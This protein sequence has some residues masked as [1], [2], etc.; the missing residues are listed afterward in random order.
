MKRAKTIL[1]KSFP[2]I[3][4]S[5]PMNRSTFVGSFRMVLQDGLHCMGEENKCERRMT[6]RV[7]KQDPNTLQVQ[8]SAIYWDF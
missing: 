5:M 6:A 1:S 2:V 8:M 4:P 7:L 3:I